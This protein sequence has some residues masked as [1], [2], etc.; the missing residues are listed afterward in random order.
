M[1]QQKAE[2][3]HNK[4]GSAHLL[5]LIQVHSAPQRHDLERPGKDAAAYHGKYGSDEEQ[6]HHN[7]A[8]VALLHTQDANHEQLE[9]EQGGDDMPKDLWPQLHPAHALYES[10]RH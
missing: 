1:T 10:A 2:C 8:G 6:W 7:R 5:M 3:I 9:H 4:A